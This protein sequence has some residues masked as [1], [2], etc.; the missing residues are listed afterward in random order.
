MC[1]QR[2]VAQ[3]GNRPQAE[4]PQSTVSR[5]RASGAE[6][7]LRESI[8]APALRTALESVAGAVREEPLARSKCNLPISWLAGSGLVG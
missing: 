6:S 7:R 8:E 3:E 1:T 2:V 4:R 5:A